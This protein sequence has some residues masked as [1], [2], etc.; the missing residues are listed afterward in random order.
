MYGRSRRHI[1]VAVA[2]DPR[3]RRQG[4]EAVEQLQR[5]Q[6]QRAVPARTGLGDLIG[7]MIETPIRWQGSG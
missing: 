3:R 6:E 1:E 2:V 5:R 7:G 4:G